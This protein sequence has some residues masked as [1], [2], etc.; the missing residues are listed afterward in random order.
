MAEWFYLDKY[1]LK[2]EGTPNDVGKKIVV[3][4]VQTFLLS[5]ARHNEHRRRVSLSPYCGTMKKGVNLSIARQINTS[6]NCC[7]RLCTCK[8]E[9]EIFLG[10][11]SVVGSSSRY[12]VHTTHATFRLSTK[13]NVTFATTA[14]PIHT[15]ECCDHESPSMWFYFRCNR[16]SA[17]NSRILWRT[18]WNLR[19]FAFDDIRR[20]E[21]KRDGKS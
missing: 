4:H 14:Y 15:C 6:I 20:N 1:L 19:A 5:T 18:Q 13:N 2:Y 11:G 12:T 3:L 7:R 16:Q 9:R 8:R 10:P 17:Y 21:V